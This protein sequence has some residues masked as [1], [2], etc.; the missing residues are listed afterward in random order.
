MAKAKR[1]TLPKDF[2]ELVRAGDAGRIRAVFDSCALD[3]TGGYEKDTALAFVGLPEEVTRWLVEQSAD[4]NARNSYQRTPLHR[5]AGHWQGEIA[6][7]LELGADPNAADQKG[8]TPLHFA[9]RVGNEAA[10]RA[11]LAAGADPGARNDAGQ[12]PLQL[13]LDQCHNAQI[14]RVARVAEVLLDATPAKPAGLLGRLL[15]RV[16][17]NPASAPRLA[18][19][20]VRIG[21]QFEF[22]RAGFNPDTVDEADA[23][24]QRLYEL[25]GVPPVPRRVMHDGKARIDPGPGS[26]QDQHQALWELLVPSSGAAATVQGEVIRLS[27]RIDYEIAVNGGANWDEGYRKMADA[28][29]IHLASGTP[30]SEAEQ[31]EAATAVRNVRTKDDA[32]LLC[33]LAVAWVTRN[34][35]PVALGRVAYNR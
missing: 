29:L 5:L 32:S 13:A 22:H 11:L 2:A 7:L 6:L 15:G 19:A 12:T 14:A 1:K 17:V 35:Q 28:L 30:L 9:A 18:E 31:A 27:G 34:P 33:E 20:V 10:V 21:E 26:W 23:G 16:P 25:F 8:Q 24:L 4:V 3:A